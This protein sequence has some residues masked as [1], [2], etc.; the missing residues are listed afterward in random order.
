[1][2]PEA[3]RSSQSSC[4]VQQV[5][6]R[7]SSWV[8][9]LGRRRACLWRGHCYRFRVCD[10]PAGP[11]PASAS[12]WLPCQPASSPEPWSLC[13]YRPDHGAARNMG[14]WFI[15]HQNGRGSFV[16]KINHLGGSSGTFCLGSSNTL[17]NLCERRG[18]RSSSICRALAATL[19]LCTCSLRACLIKKM[20]MEFESSTSTYIHYLRCRGC[21]LCR[22]FLLRLG[23]FGGFCFCLSCLCNIV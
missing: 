7:S 21:R 20:V 19:L 17:S 8:A 2:V 6:M 23:G 4:W 10:L 18:W 11:E 1:M 12:A 3:R 9:S 16:S 15:S 5:W 22:S 13:Q 14:F